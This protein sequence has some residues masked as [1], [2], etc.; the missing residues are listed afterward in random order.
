[1]GSTMLVEEEG[2]RDAGGR[3]RAEGERTE[4]RNGSERLIIP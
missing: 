2:V 3:K 1:M 4:R